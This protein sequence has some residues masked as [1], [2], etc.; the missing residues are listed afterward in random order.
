M[1]NR[2]GF[3]KSEAGNILPFT[4]GILV[5]AAILV[6]ALLNLSFESLRSAYKGQDEMQR[7]YA[8]DVGIEDALF[9]L[10]DPTTSVPLA[11]ELEDVNGYDVSV[12]IVKAEEEGFYQVTSIASKEY[13]P[14][15]IVEAEVAMY[16]L[17]ITSGSGGSVIEPGEGTFNYPADTT[18]SLLAMSDPG[19]D[20]DN[21]TGDTDT[22][23][24]P[25]AASTT[26][27]M[28]SDYAIQANFVIPP[29]GDYCLTVSSTSGGSVVNPGEGTFCYTE[30]W[31][32]DLLALEESGYRFDIWTGNT[33]NMG[34]TGASA[35]QIE[36]YGNYTI[37]ANF[38]QVFTL[39]ITSTGG[40]HVSDPGEGVCTYDMGTVVDL[41]AVNY[42]G[43]DLAYDLWT[44]DVGTVADTH[45]ASTTITMLGDYAIQANFVSQGCRPCF[46][47]AI[48][49]LSEEVTLTIDN[50]GI[51]D[52]NIYGNA[53]IELIN[54]SIID[55]HVYSDGDLVMRNVSE[56]MGNAYVRGDV[57]LWNNAEIL[58]NIY[59]DGDVQLKSAT[60]AWGDIWATGRIQ[61]GPNAEVYGTIH[62]DCDPSELPV[63]PTLDP[64]TPGEVEEARA[65]YES[66]ARAGGEL[67]DNLAI[68][69]VEN[70]GPLYIDGDLN[71]LGGAN[72]TLAGTVYVTGNI[73]IANNVTIDGSADALVAE[74]DIVI[75]NNSF[76]ET[77]S[78]LV[79]M[80][81]Y[82]DIEFWSN[83]D[84]YASLYAPNG[85]VA[86]DNPNS[87]IYGSVL[88]ETIIAKNNIDVQYDPDLAGNPNLP[89]CGCPP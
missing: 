23:A 57:I 22:I 14:N 15:T 33:S 39:T 49:S 8:A 24:N 79:I 12:N 7:F 27:T 45:S 37:V 63:M 89:G 21:W 19:Y 28:D 60:Q 16:E 44:G 50:N 71:I 5:L 66:Q 55:G 77:T 68:G 73:D 82:N 65:E 74:G 13:E 88:G 40:G 86:L 11:Y 34:N 43:Y 80:S 2:S 70:L 75:H 48:A 62:E 58:G 18:V 25:N 1:R 72:V 51:I 46:D 47:Y 69:G 41:L 53:G 81:V 29:S 42:P 61:V 78:I 87:F 35:T 67:Y 30:G 17:K 54:M 56:I 20:F 4:I 26:I 85:E 38:V 76:I 32:V 3:L 6:P 31:V 10:S 9:R 64:P 84:V 59:A 52:G 83:G 36:M